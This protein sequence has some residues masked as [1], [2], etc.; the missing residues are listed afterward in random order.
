MKT[1]ESREYRD[2]AKAVNAFYIDIHGIHGIHD[3]HGHHASTIH[4][5]FVPPPCEEFTTSE[6]SR[7]ATR[8]SPPGTII[9]SLP[10]STKGR[11]SM[12]PRATPCST[13]IWQVESDSVGWAMN[14]S[15][16]SRMRCR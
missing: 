15:G 9:T 14:F 2:A 8:V 13:E 12:C 5:S 3:I 16:A 7:N 10:D 4:V 1:R 11:K 6:P